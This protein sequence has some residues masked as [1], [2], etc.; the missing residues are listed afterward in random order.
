M[1]NNTKTLHDEKII[2]LADKYVREGFQVV[3]E[4][5]T[6]QLPFDLGNYQPDIIASKDNTGFV[7]EIK[8]SLSRIS[9]ERLKAVAEEVSKY[10]G[11]RFLLVSI[12]DIEAKSLPGTTQKLPSW[13]ELTHRFIQTHKLIENDAIEPAFLFL[14]SI[15]EGALRKR[16]VDA[17]IPIEQF[18]VIGLLRQMYSLGELSISQFDLVQACLKIRNSLAHG[19]IET[20]NLKVVHDFDNLV[21][22]LLEEWRNES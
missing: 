17:S 2:S 1:T 3:I 5:K 7:I 8:T 22:E 19:Y 4:P 18:P 12:E 16:A 11:W 14:W 21:G 9:V 13:Q 10:P 6:D 20:L 15:F